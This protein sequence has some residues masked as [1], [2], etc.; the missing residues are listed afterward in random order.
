MTSTLVRR[1]GGTPAPLHFHFLESIAYE[2]AMFKM[3]IFSYKPNKIYQE[4]LLLGRILHAMLDVF[5]MNTR[6]DTV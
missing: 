3:A 6:K 4:T 2:F 1:P 5:E